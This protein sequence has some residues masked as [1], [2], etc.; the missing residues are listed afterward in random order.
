MKKI[1]TNN[2]SINSDA[3]DEDH[4]NI[5]QLQSPCSLSDICIYYIALNINLVDSLFGFPDIV[6]IKIFQKT[7][8]LGK[9][10]LSSPESQ[11]ALRLFCDSYEGDVLSSLSVCNNHLCLNNYYDQ[12]LVFQY[13]KQL[14]ISGNGIGDDHDILHHISN[15]DRLETLCL[16]NNGLSD[17]GIRKLTSPIR[18]LK[19]GPL[20]LLHLGLS[21]NSSISSS[22]LRYL[23][24]FQFLEI[25]D[26]SNTSVRETR[27]RETLKSMNLVL[28]K[29]DDI[30][31]V[32]T[33]KNKGWTTL[34]VETWKQLTLQ[35]PD[36]PS[37]LFNRNFYQRTLKPEKAS[38]V[39]DIKPRKTSRLIFVKSTQVTDCDIPVETV[40]KSPLKSLDIENYELKEMY[41]NVKTKTSKVTLSD[42]MDSW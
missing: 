5:Q 32:F 7:E 21:E 1:K 2:V 39:S 42:L 3:V 20:E 24:C 30:P 40:H 31:D 26:V 19:K 18:M 23:K 34:T 36:K 41:G 16:R 10:K 27:V 14:D 22:V 4:S 17:D 25:L 15:L 35:P 38:S 11:A 33:I 29:E 28:Y 8:E 12:I 13:L 37:K 9:F 6:G